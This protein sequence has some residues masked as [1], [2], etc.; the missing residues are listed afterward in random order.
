M[1]VPDRRTRTVSVVSRARAV[2]LVLAASLL[3]AGCDD[4]S[5]KDSPPHA[6]SYVAL[7]DSYTS[8]PGVPTIIQEGCFRSDHNYP[9]LVAQELGLELDDVSCGGAATTAL[10]GVQ[11]TSDGPVPAQFDALTKDTD[12]VT[13][14]IGG[15][16]EGLFGELLASC[17]TLG[18]EGSTG[19]PCRDLMTQGGGDR[20][21]ETIALI[22]GRLTSSLEGIKKRAP[23]AKVVFVGYPQLAPQRGRCDTLPLSPGDYDYMHEVMITLGNATEQAAKD[24]GVLYVDL[25]HA[26][27]G[28]DVCAGP[29]AWISG[30]T[31]DPD[32]PGV[33]MHPY[34]E[35]QVAV[36]DLVVAALDD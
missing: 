27:A 17:I 3:V 8:A 21:K 1:L 36:A 19:S 11:E 2:A 5:G 29:D 14:G 25:L 16:D 33:S 18:Q 23:H 26:S 4:A 31:P 20:V 6:K 24:A 12:V 30:I 15:N 32:R 7:G 9:H 35:E 28:H 10:V 13:L 22:Q 34:A